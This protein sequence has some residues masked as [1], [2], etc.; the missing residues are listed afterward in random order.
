MTELR[1]KRYIESHLPCGCP[2]RAYW[3]DE[4]DANGE[5]VGVGNRYCR[6]HRLA[7][8]YSL[9]HL[10]VTF[11]PLVGDASG[12]GLSGNDGDGSDGKGGRTHTADGYIVSWV[13]MHRWK[14]DQR[15]KERGKA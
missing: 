12:E 14:N 13:P 8:V 15:L 9:R 5:R 7:Y 6:T 11:G 2:A 3:N 10:D 1:G 4:P